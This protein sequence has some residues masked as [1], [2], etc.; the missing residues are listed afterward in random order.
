LQVLTR[1][2]TGHMTHHIS[3]FQLDRSN[4][5]DPNPVNGTHYYA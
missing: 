2:V 5:V 1:L 3:G 4:R